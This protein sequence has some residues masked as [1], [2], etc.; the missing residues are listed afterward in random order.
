MALAMALL[1]R[2]KGNRADHPEVKSR[3][4][5]NYVPLSELA[6]EAWM[7]GIRFG[8]Q[9]PYWCDRPLAAIWLDDP[10]TDPEFSETCWLT[11]VFN[12]GPE[13]QLQPNRRT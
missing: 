10:D 5:Q 13:N 12:C 3:A 6:H 4:V 1:P 9:A 2:S 8:Q 11:H 7:L